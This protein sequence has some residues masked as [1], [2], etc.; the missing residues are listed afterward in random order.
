VVPLDGTEF[1]RLALVVA[2]ELAER[3]GA[4][5]HLLSAVERERDVAGRQEELA[6]IVRSGWTA[7][8]SVV[9]DRDPAGVIHQ[10]VKHLGRA[11]ACLANHG[12][13]RSMTLRA[14]VASE[15]IARGGDSVMV[16]GPWVGRPKGVWW[17][18]DPISLSQFRGGGVVA[19]LNGTVT[20][21]PLVAVALR[22]ALALGEPMIALT[23]AEQIPPLLEESRIVRAFGPEG[24]VDAFLEQVLAPAW[25]TGV[26]VVGVPVYDPVGPAEGVLSYLEESPP[27]LVVVGAHH[28]GRNDEVAIGGIP[29]AIVRRSPSPVLI[30]PQS[31]SRRDR[32]PRPSRRL[33]PGG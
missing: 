14:S 8:V 19:C 22:W 16:A 26:K 13:G 29:A 28:R 27:T 18:D 31:G 4:G 1:A 5:V 15:V 17:S 10:T 20:S 2:Q 12:R 7:S 21:G 30:V 24:N 3:I 32:G 6:A 9:V 23:V 25:G 33:A 11:I